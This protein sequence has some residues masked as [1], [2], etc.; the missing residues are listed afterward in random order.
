[1]TA[2]PKHTNSLLAFPISLN[3]FY[4]FPWHLIHSKQTYDVSWLSVCSSMTVLFCFCLFGFPMY[5]KHLAEGG[6]SMNNCSMKECEQNTCDLW[7]QERYSPWSDISSPWASFCGRD[8]D[9]TSGPE[10][11]GG[12][13]P[14]G[15]G[16]M[17][18]AIRS[19]THDLK[20]KELFLTP[21]HPQF[22]FFFL[23]TRWFFF[24]L[25]FFFFFFF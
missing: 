2:H 8:L 20:R 11:A 22:F 15:G 3:L 9:E 17:E 14:G 6:R 13:P 10:S 18:S 23:R 1:M 25:N 7:C 19:R 5:P 16:S 4:F 12:S 21:P 24:F